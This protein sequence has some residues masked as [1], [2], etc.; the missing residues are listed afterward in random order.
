[1]RFCIKGEEGRHFPIELYEALE[2]PYPLLEFE[3]NGCSF[4]PD[5]WRHYAIW[6]AC[7]IH[8]YHYSDAAPLGGKW[9]SR[10]EADRILR[11]NIKILLKQQGANRFLRWWLPHTYWRSVRIHG[12]GAFQGWVE[13]E[14]PLSLRHR[15]V[16]GF[17]W[18]RDKRIT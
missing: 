8:D 17:G 12:D 5:W 9:A 10:R 3:S 6:P 15:V 16:E 18:F 2:G 11:K 4:S 1:M 13:N 14:K 7:H